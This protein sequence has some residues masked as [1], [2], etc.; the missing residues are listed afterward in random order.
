MNGNLRRIDLGNWGRIIT[1]VIADNVMIPTEFIWGETPPIPTIRAASASSVAEIR[2]MVRNYVPQFDRNY[3]AQDISDALMIDY[4]NI[5]RDRGFDYEFAKS[6]AQVAMD[7]SDVRNHA[8]DNMGTMRSLGFQQVTLNRI[9]NLEYLIGFK[10]TADGVEVIIAFN[11]TDFEVFPNFPIRLP[12]IS[13][14]TNIWNMAFADLIANA[15]NNVVNGAHEGYSQMAELFASQSGAIRFYASPII[16]FTLDDLIERSGTQ[17]TLVGHSMGGAIAQTYAI[18]LMNR[19]VPSANIRGYTFNSALA[20]T[21]NQRHYHLD[22]QWFNIMNRTDNVPAGAVWFSLQ[23]EG[24]R[25][26]F[27]ISLNDPFRPNRHYALNFNIPNGE[28][29]IWY[30]W[31]VLTHEATARVLAVR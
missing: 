31:D 27:D 20:I 12:D 5:L 11:G 23:S 19:G 30:L 25:L 2:R 1:P 22:M 10:D 28:H 21:E 6:M 16:T 13:D 3:S 24:R 26:G 18:Y 9:N 4:I 29:S 7:V 14:P 15:R 17:F 8:R